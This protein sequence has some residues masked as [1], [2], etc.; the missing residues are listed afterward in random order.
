MGAMSFDY[1][2]RYYGV[3]AA[4]KSPV[5]YRGK[6]GIVVGARGPYVRVRLEGEQEIRCYHPMDLE[7]QMS[8]N[9]P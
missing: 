2:R 3:P 4:H 1:I 7:W 5:A 8:D 9:K 6:S